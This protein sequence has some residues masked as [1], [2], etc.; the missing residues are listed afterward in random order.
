VDPEGE[1]PEAVSVAPAPPPEPIR[2]AKGQVMRTVE[3]VE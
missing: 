1:G 3:R 2:D